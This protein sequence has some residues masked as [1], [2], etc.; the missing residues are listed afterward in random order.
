[1]SFVPLMPAGSLF[2]PTRTEF[3]LSE[4]AGNAFVKC[5]QKAR[6]ADAQSLAPGEGMATVGEN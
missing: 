2:G 3:Q 1:M 5:K 4:D 6:M